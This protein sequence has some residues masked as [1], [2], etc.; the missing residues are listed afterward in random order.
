M[1][2][3][4]STKLEHNI[5]NNAFSSWEKTKYIIFMT[6]IYSFTGPAYMLTPSFGPKPPALDSLISFLSTIAFVLI[7]YFG[8]K[9]CHQTN[10][11]VDDAH[12][13]ERFTILNVPLTIK[14]MLIFLPAFLFIVLFSWTMS[15]DEEIRKNIISYSMRVIAPVGMV[16]YY[17]FLNRS[18]ERLG[19]LMI[20]NGKS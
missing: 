3:I 9:K 8:I 15:A 16:I 17:I 11:A 5:A 19:Q 1:I 20:K 10:K 4:S 7:T 6:A 18:F 12:F 13:I 2:L 14:F